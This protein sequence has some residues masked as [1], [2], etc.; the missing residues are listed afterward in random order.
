M[1]RSRLFV[2]A[3][4]VL[5]SFAFFVPEYEYPEYP[6]TAEY[7][8]NALFGWST[9]MDGDAVIVGAYGVDSAH[10]FEYNGED[11]I[12]KARLSDSSIDYSEYGYTVSIDGNTAV[13]GAPKDKEAGLDAGAV[14]VYRRTGSG[15]IEEDK[16]IA[17]EA[18]SGA[19]FGHAVA[20]AGNVIVVGAPRD[21]Y[22]SGDIHN[23][24]QGLAYV[25]E[26]NGTKW[27]EIATLFAD[28]GVTNDWFGYA[29]D[30]DILPSGDAVAFIG[31]HRDLNPDWGNKLGA[32][33]VFSNAGGSWSQVQKLTAD[34]VDEDPDAYPRFGWSVSIDGETAVIG[35]FGDSEVA[36]AAGAVHVFKLEDG[37]WN[38]KEK[39][40]GSNIRYLHCSGHSVSVS[41]DLVIV[42]SAGDDG[43]SPYFPDCGASYVFRFDGLSWVE[44]AHLYAS[45]F[46]AQS[47]AW[48]GHSVSIDGNRF[49][50]GSPRRD[51]FGFRS[52]KAYIYNIVP[53][54]PTIPDI[55]DMVKDLNL[56]HG[57]ENSF[58]SK[59]ENAQE[60]L[61]DAN[62]N[63]ASG[64]LGSMIVPLEKL[65]E[66][67]DIPAEEGQD[68]IDY[69]QALIDH[70]NEGLGKHVMDDQIAPNGFELD[71]NY[72]NPFNPSTTIAIGLPH[73]ANV[74]LKIYDV[75]GVLVNTLVSGN[76]SAGIHSF[77]W[78][79]T[80]SSGQQVSSGIYI[81]RLQ[82]DEFSTMKR[83]VFV[84]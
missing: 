18:K 33:Y 38:E 41:G 5:V 84:K 49:I 69:I 22:H 16:I 8:P 52:G 63:A 65:I 82:A 25:F 14:F 57:R 64:Q 51:A 67:G 76:L 2:A 27:N 20:V 1:K 3:A 60:S 40:F 29:V 15:W 26:H 70:L 17:D 36:Y 78:D 62:S 73:S 56:P 10:V 21:D 23:Y 42:G 7:V 54:V 77:F 30:V 66:K 59:L 83:M 28:D 72:P 32:V 12:E 31:E 47:G 79:G 34:Y 81:Y 35:A 50:V 39:L 6:L 43:L 4:I 48:F 68:I 58:L 75:S 9:S 46:D 55:I 71:Q 19:V 45:D 11:W 61:N 44:E 53:A 13:V 24:D 80:N 74:T 37:I